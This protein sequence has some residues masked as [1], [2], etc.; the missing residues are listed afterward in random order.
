MRK[1]KTLP[2]HVFSCFFCEEQ[3]CFIRPSPAKPPVPV[4]AEK[5]QPLLPSQPS[6]APSPPSA[7]QPRCA[8]PAC[9]P[10]RRRRHRAGHRRARSTRPRH[11]TPQAATGR[12]VGGRGVA[13]AFQVLVER[14]TTRATATGKETAQVSSSPI[15]ID[16]RKSTCCHMLTTMALHGS[17]TYRPCVCGYRP[18]QVAIP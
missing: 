10:P 18:S 6:P 9:A 3:I 7:S 2:N 11:P 4:V 5:N 15:S 16:L 14:R 12:V 1:C 8:A 17:P 13:V